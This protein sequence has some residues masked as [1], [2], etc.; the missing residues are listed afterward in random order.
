MS[1]KTIRVKKRQPFHLSDCQKIQNG[2]IEKGYYATLDQCH[3]MWNLYSEDRWSVG[4]VSMT[5]YDNQSIF[6][7]LKDYFEVDIIT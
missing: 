4:W 1:I 3:E 2:L 7:A 5:D 6:Y